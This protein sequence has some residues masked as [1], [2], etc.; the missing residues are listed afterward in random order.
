[1]EV[2]V[3]T[4]ESEV[5]VHPEACERAVELI[6]SLGLEGQA[7]LIGKGEKSA[8]QRCRFR[9]WTDEEMR[10]Y[11]MLLPRSDPANR[12]MGE[13]MPLRV[14]E[15]FAEAQAL[16]IFE[17]F[18]VRHAE[19]GKDPLLLAWMP[20]EQYR[21]TRYLIARWGDVLDSFPV[22]LERVGRIAIERARRS[23][24][25]I[26]AQAAAFL[27]ATEDAKPTV[28]IEVPVAYHLDIPSV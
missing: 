18:E 21:A 16:G 15:A 20:T 17:G 27:A 10:V 11:T 12:Y 22:L 7:Q 2:E 1:M 24:K 9:A 13:A 3:Y 5:E 23:A 28:R 14:L 19:T 26:Q 6:E 25:L 4:V 8:K